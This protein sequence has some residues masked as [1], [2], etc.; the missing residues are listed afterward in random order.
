MIRTRWYKVFSDL[1]GNRGRTLVVALAI[2]VGVY[3]V[4]VIVDAQNLL[5]RE[6]GSD[7]EEALVSSATVYTMPFTEDLAERVAKLEGVSAAEG[8]QTADVYAYDADGLRKDLLITAVP[9]FEN[10]TVDR[11][12]PVAG[13]WPPGTHEILLERLALDYL[14]VAIGDT[15][16]L[17]RPDGK[18]N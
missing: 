2:A 14:D 18:S 12:T 3:A 17:E 6:H 4:G 16:Y 8:R 11:V 5:I 9:D 10:M 1:W 15:L 7:V 13:A